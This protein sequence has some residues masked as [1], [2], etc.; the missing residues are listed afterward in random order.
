MKRTLLVFAKEPV[1]G[2]VKT[3]LLP[4]LSPLEAAELSHAFLAD[5]LD[6]LRGI[7]GLELWVAIPPESSAERM[8][9]RHEFGVRWVSQGA[10]D[11]GE[12]MN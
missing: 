7:T 3:R 10:G 12:R 6:R 2:A 4:F 8:A 9:L 1:P 11:L 5:L